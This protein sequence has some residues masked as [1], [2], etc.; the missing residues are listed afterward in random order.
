MTAIAIVVQQADGM[1]LPLVVGKLETADQTTLVVVTN[2]DGYDVFFRVPLPF[3]GVLKLQARDGSGKTY[4]QPVTIPAGAVNVT[5]RV[6]G[7]QV[8][9]QD[10]LLPAAVPFA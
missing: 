9:P 10:V 1:P 2:D 6:G 8:N 4:A 7:T 3:D 5:L